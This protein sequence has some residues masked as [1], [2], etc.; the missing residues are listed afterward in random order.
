MNFFQPPTEGNQTKEE[1]KQV[2]SMSVNMFF[3]VDVQKLLTS[4]TIIPAN[5]VF[6][7]SKNTGDHILKIIPSG[8]CPLRYGDSNAVLQTLP[9]AF[10]TFVP[11][12]NS[13]L[14]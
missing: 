3:T 7:L 10:C 11:N 13:S 1:L 5:I 14:N 9:D 2:L 8:K 4:R 12:L 6:I